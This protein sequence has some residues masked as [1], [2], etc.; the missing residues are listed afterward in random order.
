MSELLR[1]LRD[2]CLLRIAPQDL[3]CNP[4]LLGMLLG[5]NVLLATLIGIVLGMPVQALA[6]SVIS[7][8][9]VLGGIWFLLSARELQPRFVQTALAF[10]AASLVFNL[11]GTP[12]K[13]AL[14]PMPLDPAQLAGGQLLAAFVLV[15][16]GMWMLAVNGHILKNALERSFLSGLLLAFGLDL[17]AGIVVLLLVAGSGA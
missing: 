3:P 9:V 8:A 7:L 11:L 14:V 17:A 16:L 5:A 10:A 12:A 2:L 15:G 13:L 6:T 4:S 1:A